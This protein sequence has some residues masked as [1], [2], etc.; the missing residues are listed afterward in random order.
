MQYHAKLPNKLQD[1]RENS[2]SAVACVAFIYPTY[3][4]SEEPLEDDV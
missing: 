4:V 3:A 2:L 1:L